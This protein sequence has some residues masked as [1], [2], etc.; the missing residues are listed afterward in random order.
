MKGVGEGRGEGAEEGRRKCDRNRETNLCRENKIERLGEGGGAVMTE[1][2]REIGVVKRKREREREREREST[3]E[4]YRVRVE[5][6][7]EK[8]RDGEGR[9]ESVKMAKE[10]LE[11]DKVT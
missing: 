9:T 1:G 11:R 8:E 6:E 3:R 4:K 5:R 10:E 2:Q 7:R